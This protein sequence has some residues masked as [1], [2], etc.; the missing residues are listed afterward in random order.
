MEDPLEPGAVIP[1]E[2]LAP[3]SAPV[4]AEVALGFR[5]PRLNGAFDADGN[6]VH[7][8]HGYDD[9]EDDGEDD[10]DDWNDEE[11]EAAFFQYD[12]GGLTSQR[13]A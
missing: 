2:T 7:Y 12:S 9:D 11:Y 5:T 13:G 4:P 1:P 6:V 3:V 8:T 10:D